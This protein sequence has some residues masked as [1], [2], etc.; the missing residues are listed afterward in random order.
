MAQTVFQCEGCLSIF[1]I[2]EAADKC[3]AEHSLEGLADWLHEKL[4]TLDHSIA[5]HRCSYLSE[6]WEQLL[7]GATKNSWLQRA[8]E[9]K[10]FSDK[11][12][13]PIED[14]LIFMIRVS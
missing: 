4:C 7:K 12:K 10:E 14:L 13:V 9:F 8:K 3:N 5:N 6:H 11:Q 1:E 2:E